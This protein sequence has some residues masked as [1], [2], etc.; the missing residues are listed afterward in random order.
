[1]N[2]AD[3]TYDT[4]GATDQP[5]ALWYGVVRGSSGEL[6]EV[7]VI[8]ED[9]EYDHSLL[10]SGATFFGWRRPDDVVRDAE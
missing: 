9:P 4:P 2:K 8:R 10:C 5:G 7:A 3:M 1:M 6:H